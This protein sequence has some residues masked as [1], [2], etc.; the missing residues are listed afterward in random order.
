MS[1]TWKPVNSTSCYTNYETCS[2]FNRI[3]ESRNPPRKFSAWKPIL[4]TFLSLFGWK[5]IPTLFASWFSR[6][7]LSSR[8]IDIADNPLKMS[9]PIL[10]RPLVIHSRFSITSPIFYLTR[11]D[12]QPDPRE[13]I[14]PPRSISSWIYRYCFAEEGEPMQMMQKWS[15]DGS[16]IGYQNF[17]IPGE[18]LFHERNKHV[19][20]IREE[21]GIRMEIEGNIPLG[22]G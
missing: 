19:I 2:I 3:L 21:N 5:S 20:N 11:S 12:F 15:K 9:H 8:K 4:L 16:C 10:V 17:S 6:T 14:V 18:F 22:S 1:K 13:N 7:L